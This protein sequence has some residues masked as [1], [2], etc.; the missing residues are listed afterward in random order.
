MNKK[1]IRLTEQD[2]HKIVKESVNKILT[3]MDWKTYAN[4]AKKRAEQGKDDK[5][6][7]LAQFATD[8]FNDKFGHDELDGT[9]DEN[10]LP[11]HQDVKGTV[12][13]FGNA[14]GGMGRW[15]PMHAQMHAGYYPR[16]DKDGS[17]VFNP[18]SKMK[19]TKNTIDKYQKAT[20]EI[21]KFDRGDSKYVKGKGWQ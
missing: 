18:R 3:E 21:G 9:Y 13:Q 4:A 10:G 19:P 16:Q 7:D 11:Y 5:A 14:Y 6:E 17:H 15:T 1:L 2:L 20:D 8:R 12:T